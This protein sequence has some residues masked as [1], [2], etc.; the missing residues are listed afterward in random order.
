MDKQKMGIIGGVVGLCALIVCIGVVWASF[1]QTLTIDGTATVKK[2]NWKIHFTRLSGF[3][4]E[5]A[6]TLVGTAEVVTAPI[7]KEG[8]TAIG[9]YEVTLMTPGDS[10]TYEIDITND[11]TYDAVLKTLSKSA[12]P[13]CNGTAT[14]SA[15]AATDALNVCN[16]LSYT[17]TYKD[18]GLAVGE[19]DTLNAGQTRTVILKL[20]YHDFTDASLL[21]TNDVKISNL[22]ISMIYAQV[23]PPVRS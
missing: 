14:D 8:A 10:V 12:K 13:T 6:P 3:E 5:K 17:F 16:K 21:P 20:E 1:T 11:G 4:E 18:T 9:D 7:I 23:A 19:G 2:S 22:G 15:Q